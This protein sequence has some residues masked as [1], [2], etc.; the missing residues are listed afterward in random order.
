MNKVVDFPKHKIVREVPVDIEEVTKAKEK[1]L[2][3]FADGIVDDMIGN[4][5][6]ELD[7]YGLDTEGENFDKDFSFAMD[8]LR[9]CVFRALGMKHHLHEFLDTNVTM[10]KLSDIRMEIE[11]ETT[12]MNI[13]EIE[14]EPEFDMDDESEEN[15][16]DRP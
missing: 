6:S 10:K 15:D 3:N 16:T 4:I 8:G 9:A 11:N 7:N 14:F 1:G 12:K 5:Y 13:D 2:L